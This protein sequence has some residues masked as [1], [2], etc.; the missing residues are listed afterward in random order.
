MPLCKDEDIRRGE[1]CWESRAGGWKRMSN[2]E[3]CMSSTTFCESWTARLTCVSPPLS[4]CTSSPRYFRL[5][6]S[7]VFS[8]VFVESSVEF[9]WSSLCLSLPSTADEN[10]FTQWSSCL[11]SAAHGSTWSTPACHMV[12]ALFRKTTTLM[13]PPY[14]TTYCAFKTASHAFIVSSA[15][16]LLMSSM[17][18]WADSE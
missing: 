14:F 3:R 16:W 2:M 9:P 1:R 8:S 15:V 12:A 11:L 7:P 5:Y 4:T 18:T 6:L 10:I 13:T 17:S